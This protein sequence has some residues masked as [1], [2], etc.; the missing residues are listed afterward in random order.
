MANE[1]DDRVVSYELAVR[2][3]KAGFDERVLGFWL[4]TTPSTGQKGGYLNHYKSYVHHSNTEWEQEFNG[5]KE[6]VYKNLD[7]KHPIISAPTYGQVL[8]WFQN[9]RR[10]IIYVTFSYEESWQAYVKSARDNF[11]I[12]QHFVNR[13][14]AYDAAFGSVLKLF[15]K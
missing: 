13:D 14:E 11:M 15:G 12:A 1:I 6:K 7:T 5:L 2:L 10:I 9:K 3:K 8:D 4:Y